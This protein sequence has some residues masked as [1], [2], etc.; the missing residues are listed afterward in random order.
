MDRKKII[1]ILAIIIVLFVIIFLISLIWKKVENNKEIKSGI[2][3]VVIA[4]N[5]AFYKKSKTEN[6][7]QI[8]LLNKGENVYIL[9]SFEEDGVKW[10]KVKVNKKKNGFVRQE[11]VEYFEEINKEKVLVSDVSK[12]NYESDFKTSGDYEVFLLDNKISY[13]Y[14][15]AGGRGYGEKGNLYTDETYNMFVDACEYLGIPYGFYFFDE[16]LNDKEIKEEVNFIKKFL[17][18][19]KGENSI[20]PVVIDVEKHNGSGRADNIWNDRAPLVQEL[21]DQLKNENISSIVYSNAQTANLYLSSLD[22]KFWLAYYPNDGKIPSYWYFDTDQ[23][24]A[25]NLDLYKKTIGWQFSENGA[26]DEIPDTVDLSLFK[27]DFYK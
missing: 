24:G 1:K 14:I 25:K 11:T 13:V 19:N 18:E 12:Y 3:G 27:A 16:A 23:D 6:V 10:Y 7:K 26:D 21:I 2:H 20:L 9:D 17:N 15:R 5:V 22:T 4:D 8:R